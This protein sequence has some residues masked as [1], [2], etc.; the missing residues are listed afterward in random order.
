MK[1]S[2]RFMKSG[3]W[4]ALL[5]C[6]ALSGCAVTGDGVIYG[7]DDSTDAS[8]DTGV[9]YVEPAGVV[10]GGWE[11]TYNVAPPAPHI[12]G[13]GIPPVGMH[14]TPGTPPVRNPTPGG[15]RPTPGGNATHAYN[16]PPASHS[17]PSI[18]TAHHK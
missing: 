8:F 3:A 9:D 11:H 6:A 13:G 16:P 17:A 15:I 4:L 1:S 18:P 12:V 14:Q 7:A 5:L 2:S 10:V